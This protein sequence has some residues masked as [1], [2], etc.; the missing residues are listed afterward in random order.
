MTSMQSG[1]GLL[2]MIVALTFGIGI[3]RAALG[4]NHG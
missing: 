2:G 3:T 4:R 1:P